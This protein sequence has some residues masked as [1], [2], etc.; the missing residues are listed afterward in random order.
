MRVNRSKRRQHTLFNGLIVNIQRGKERAIDRHLH[1]MWATTAWVG[2]WTHRGPLGSTGIHAQR[3]R[4]ARRPLDFTPRQQTRLLFRLPINYTCQRFILGIGDLKN[5]ADCPRKRTRLPFLCSAK[6]CSAFGETLLREDQR[7]SAVMAA[8]L[9]LVYVHYTHTKSSHLEF[10]GK[11]LS[12]H[13]MPLKK[14]RNTREEETEH[15]ITLKT[16]E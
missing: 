12:G 11:F 1:L 2:T 3:P 9:S 15:R 13:A 7:R 5:R 16:Q 4:R 6:L 8:V 10:I 14:K